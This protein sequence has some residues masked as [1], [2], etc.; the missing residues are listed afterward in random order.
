[1]ML[2]QKNDFYNHSTMHQ[3]EPLVHGDSTNI[4]PR[5]HTHEQQRHSECLGLCAAGDTQTTSCSRL[6]NL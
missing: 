5:T 2:L 6:L 3:R 1:M 4:G